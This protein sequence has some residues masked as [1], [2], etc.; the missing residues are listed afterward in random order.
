V[1]DLEL[2]DPS[3]KRWPVKKL[4]FLIL[5]VLLLPSYSLAKCFGDY[6]G[7]VYIQNYDSDTITFNLTS[8]YPIISEKISIR[9]NDIDTPWYFNSEWNY[10]T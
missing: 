5:P 8:L 1:A 10:S 6:E 2:C 7:V 4:V 3:S 9:V